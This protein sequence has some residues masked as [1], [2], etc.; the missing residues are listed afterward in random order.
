MT[1]CLFSLQLQATD[2]TRAHVESD[3]KK[4]ES[5]FF[6]TQMFHDNKFD[7][8]KR[9]SKQ[10]IPQTNPEVRFSPFPARIFTF[11]LQVSYFTNLQDGKPRSH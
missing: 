5:V 9:K 11:Y 6:P 3:W 2:Q 7:T 1:I 8:L 10:T 4:N